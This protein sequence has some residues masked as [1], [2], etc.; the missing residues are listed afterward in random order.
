MT[1]KL[2][3]KQQEIVNFDE[4]ALLVTA[5]PGNGK[6][7][8]LIERIKRLLL[9]RKR[10]KILAL[11]FSNLAAEEMKQRLNS[12]QE[13]EELIENVNIGT[14]HSFALDLVQRRGNLVGL[15]EELTL[16]ESDIDR[17]RMLR[18]VLLEDIDFNYILKQQKEPEKFIKKY[19]DRI[20]K[21]KKMLISPE[22]YC[23]DN[24]FKR[25]YMEYNRYLLQQNAIDFDDI[26]F[27]A[28]NILIGNPGVQRMYAS[29]Y[30]Y[31]C[32]DEAQDLNFAQYELI[33]ALCGDNIKNV[34][35]VGDANQSIY[36]FNGSNSELM[37]KNF[38]EDFKPQIFELCENF[39]SAKKIV[40]YA[41][42]LE[43]TKNSSKTDY[44][45]E[46]EVKAY[47]CKDEA[48]EA[49]FVVGQIINL[50]E[51][52]HTDIEKILEYEDFAVIARNRYALSEVE[53][54]LCTQNIPYF[55]KKTISRIECESQYIKIFDLA[56]RVFLNKNDSVHRRE[57]CALIGDEVEEKKSL[58]DILSNTLYSGIV[59]ALEYMSDDK[60][61]FNKGIKVIKENI[62]KLGEAIN[63]EEKY[64]ILKDLEQWE[65][66]WKK[67]CSIVPREN[68]T[69]LSFRNS[70]SLGKTQDVS[71]NKGVALL[72]AHM[73]KGLQYEVVF[74]VG[75]TEG[76]F[77]DYR[78]V[79][80]GGKEIKQEENIMFVAATRA[81]RLCYFTYPKCKRMPWGDSKVQE[82]TRFLENIQVEAV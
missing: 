8:V 56:M 62:E 15:S 7:S 38:V 48:A 9:S 33:K 2:S 47:E 3:A 55:Y 18:D 26:L 75:L 40:E 49:E 52:G 66:H 13:V 6:T 1:L 78:A 34:M 29:I 59:E 57:L 79:A 4:G 63:E 76:T 22:A 72:T 81:K 17:Q 21:Q 80:L 69:L 39:R 45:Y 24:D 71:G 46:G 73:S 37:S 27:F 70:I 32:V 54:K 28:Y 30:K 77:P 36:G 10:C 42:Q 50:K 23:G 19:M 25:I 82:K 20:A 74:V 58:E 16:F 60:F 31:I 53:E 67:Y 61:D 11:T 44:H 65:K 14:I 5:G 64:L 68:R 41:N 51:K 35:F 43:N 12:D